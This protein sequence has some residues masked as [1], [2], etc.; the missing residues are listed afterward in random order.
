M[1]IA[2]RILKV[3]SRPWKDLQFVQTEKLK[4]FPPELKAKLRESIIGNNFVQTFV[5][6]EDKGKLLCLDG[7]HRVQVLKELEAEGYRVPAELPCVFVQCKNRAE[8]AKLVLVYSSS[9]TQMFREAVTDFVVDNRLDVDEIA[10]QVNLL[11]VD[12]GKKGGSGDRPEDEK[13]EPEYPIV[14][15]FSEHYDYL[16]IFCKNEIEWGSLSTRMDLK[17]KKSYKNTGVGVGRLIP[18][19]EFDRIWQK[20]AK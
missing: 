11:F 20:R 16:I 5:V 1:E 6:W 12:L 19:A 18:F 13:T 4:A 2:N 17:T 10:T 3:E 14:A 8:A 9:Y 7:F 15:R